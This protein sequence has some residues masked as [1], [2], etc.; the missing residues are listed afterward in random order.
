M[1]SGSGWTLKLIVTPAPCRSRINE[2]MRVTITTKNSHLIPKDRRSNLTFG[3]LLPRIDPIN[4]PS[5][6]HENPSA[7][8]IET[9][10]ITLDE[11]VLMPA[12]S[13]NFPMAKRKIERIK[14]RQTKK[15]RSKYA[16]IR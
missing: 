7:I 3:S 5:R 9:S 16:A 15:A 13:S 4:K 10:K 2:I 8:K 1:C 11:I 12:N 14:Y 6:R